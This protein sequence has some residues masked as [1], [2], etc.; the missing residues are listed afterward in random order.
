MLRKLTAS[1]TVVEDDGGG[2][3]RTMGLS[4]GLVRGRPPTASF[5]SSGGTQLVALHHQA[6]PSIFFVH[7]LSEL[8][9]LTA[10][11]YPTI[12]S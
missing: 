9:E 8:L 1:I 3:G 10:C 4:V 6:L 2:L 11:K 12:S 7:H 5:P